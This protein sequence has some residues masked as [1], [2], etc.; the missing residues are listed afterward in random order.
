MMFGA[1]R[2]IN[3]TYRS[4][5]RLRG[6]VAIFMRHGL[7]GLTERVHLHLLVPIHRRVRKK[8][9]SDKKEVLSTA[10]RLRLSFEELGPTFA[11][12]GQLIASRPDLAPAEYTEEFKK[13]M[14]KVPPFPFRE[15]KRL[16]EEQFD[17]PLSTI[18]AEF[19]EMPVAAASIAQVHNAVL[20]DG[21]EVVVKVQRPHIER[22]IDTDI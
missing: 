22:I 3:L 16:I 8:R 11:K 7:Y 4:L 13:L 21:T 12:L 5:Q 6:I 18:F 17:A 2:K 10:V 14:D 19:E 9:I 1:F 20:H 15:V